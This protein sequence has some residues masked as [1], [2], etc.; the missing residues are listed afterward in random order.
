MSQL[1]KT[2]NSIA[3]PAI[4]IAW[5]VCGVVLICQYK[6]M[7]PWLDYWPEMVIV[8][9]TAIPPALLIL[10]TIVEAAKKI[11]S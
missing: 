11:L 8:L 6:G 1:M 2:I 10:Y 5:V 9:I 3:T 4:F 7:L